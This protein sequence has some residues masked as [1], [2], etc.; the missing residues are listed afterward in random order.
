MK[1]KELKE[2][3][4]LKVEGKVKKCRKCKKWKLKEEFSADKR[5]KDG[6]HS[7]CKAC[8]NKYAKEKYH[9]NPIKALA[10]MLKEAP[11]TGWHI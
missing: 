5:N 2:L 6:L 9:Q 1:E 8:R 11:K 7:Y 4:I 10:K 3:T